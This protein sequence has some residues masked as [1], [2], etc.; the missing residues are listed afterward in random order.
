MIHNKH[1]TLRI[2]F[3][4]DFRI[5]ICRDNVAPGNH[6]GVT[7]ADVQELRA[8][9]VSALG[10]RIQVQ[11]QVAQ[12]GDIML[13]ILA[14]TLR[15]VDYAI[16]ITGNFQGHKWRWARKKGFT[17]VPGN[18]DANMGGLESFDI[19]TYYLDDMLT[20]KIIDNTEPYTN[21]DNSG[22]TLEIITHGQAAI[23][24]GEII[25]KADNVTLSDD[26]EEVIITV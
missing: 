10:R 16:E 2:P 26:D 24:D 8:C 18:E 22:E 20:A 7:F 25:I 15:C 21:N 13:N 17:I 11:H 4:N 3:G 12:D 6:T 23:I 1:H 9:I 14:E 5:A 19:E